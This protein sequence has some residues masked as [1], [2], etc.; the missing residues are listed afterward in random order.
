[1]NFAQELLV[2]LHQILQSRK[3][4]PVAVDGNSIDAAALAGLQEPNGTTAFTDGMHGSTE[5]K[6]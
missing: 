6:A 5:L 1:M 2:V 4:A 3:A